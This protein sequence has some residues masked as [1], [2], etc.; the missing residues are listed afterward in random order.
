MSDQWKNL[1]KFLLHNNIG[2]ACVGVMFIIYISLSGWGASKIEEG[3]NPSDLVAY[4]SHFKVYI[5]SN[6]ET[7][8][9]CPIVMIILDHPVNYTKETRDKIFDF[10][11]EAQSVD[12]IR[13]DLMINWMDYFKDE[14]ERLD[15]VG[16]NESI[17]DKMMN[18][19]SPFANDIVIK[20]NNETGRKEI[21][22]SRFYL[23]WEWLR[24]T[25]FDVNVMVNL[26]KLSASNTEL[27]PIAYSNYFKHI[28]RMEYTT[29]NIIQSFVIGVE[30]MYIIS[31]L[32]IPDLISIACIII[33]MISIMV[34]LIACMHLW[35]LTLSPITMT[36]L[37]LSVGFC[38]DFSAHLTHAF[39]SSVGKG[40]RSKRAYNACMRIGLPIFNSAASTIL[41]IC[42]LGFSNSYFFMSFFK[43]IFIL[44]ALGVLHSMV[45]LPVLLS[46]IGPHWSRHKETA[47]EESAQNHKSD[48]IELASTLLK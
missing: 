34:G 37:I 35:G 44:M 3:I 36:L 1:Y 31:L 6:V 23:Q 9:L 28:E 38:I 19:N 32:F 42:V 22:A 17:F 13:K 46:I 11:L 5:D 48:D 21:I 39:I 18:D 45:F 4:D 27:K 25:I 14:L 40:S 15:S 24:F 26:R 2:K 20:Y 41:G 16:Y 43:T 30:T 7:V 8:N 33:S 12:G 47:E 10:L 29:S